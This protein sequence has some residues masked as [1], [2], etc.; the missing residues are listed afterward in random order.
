[1]QRGKSFFHYHISLSNAALY[2]SGR[3]LCRLLGGYSRV[4]GHAGLRSQTPNNVVF[5]VMDA[6]GGPSTGRR[7]RTH[8]GARHGV[9]QPSYC[10]RQ[11]YLVL[12]VLHHSSQLPTER[13]APHWWA[14]E[15]LRFGTAFTKGACI[16][17]RCFQLQACPACR[18]GRKQGAMCIT[19]S[20][21]GS[22]AQ[23]CLRSPP[24]AYGLLFSVFSESQPYV[25][26]AWP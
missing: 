6:P 11:T 17:K 19:G 18:S 21:R 12:V 1:M 10:S 2:S 23:S 14:W 13:D 20:E 24:H 4:T 9:Q 8:A 3:I 5:T 25:C 22:Q 16:C 15:L 7:C 26:V